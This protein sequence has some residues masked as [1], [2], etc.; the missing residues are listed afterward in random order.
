MVWFDKL[1]RDSGSS[2][3]GSVERNRNPISWSLEGLHAMLQPRREKQQMARGRREG[4][5][6][7]RAYPRQL[8]SPSL[9]HRHRWAARIPEDNLP[10]F[11]FLPDFDRIKRRAEASR[12]AVA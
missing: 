12:V 9:V 10:A 11:H 3:V 7:A 2:R 5:T 8:D 6:I 4:Y 1:T